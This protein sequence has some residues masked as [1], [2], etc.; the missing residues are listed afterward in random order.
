MEWGHLIAPQAEQT[1][2]G[3]GDPV[4]SWEEAC[5]WFGLRSWAVAFF[6]IFW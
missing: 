4:A 5:L 1:H 2:R 3:G 6:R